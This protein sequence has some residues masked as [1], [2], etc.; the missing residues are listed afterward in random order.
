MNENKDAKIIM[1]TRD[2]NEASVVMN[3]SDDRERC[4]Y[5]QRMCNLYIN[6]LVIQRVLYLTDIEEYVLKEHPWLQIVFEWAKDFTLMDNLVQ[7]VGNDGTTPTEAV[8]KYLD[9]VW[10]IF[11]KLSEITGLPKEILLGERQ[12]NLGIAVEEEARYFIEAPAEELDEYFAKA[13]SEYTGY[14][15]GMIDGANTKVEPEYLL[16]R[17]IFSEL[18]FYKEEDLR[19]AQRLIDRGIG[20]YTI[21]H[22][23]RASDRTGLER[24][25]K[26]NEY[27]HFGNPKRIKQEMELIRKE[28]RDINKNPLGI[29]YVGAYFY[30]SVMGKIP[31]FCLSDEKKNAILNTLHNG[32][33]N[34]KAVHEAYDLKQHEILWHEVFSPVKYK[35]G[36]RCYYTDEDRKLEHLKISYNKIAQNMRL[37]NTIAEK[38]EYYRNLLASAGE[39]DF[40]KKV[41]CEDYQK[42]EKQVKEKEKQ[43]RAVED[44]LR[45]IVILIKKYD[46]DILRYEQKIK[47]M[48]DDTDKTK[49]EQQLA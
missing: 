31:N 44:R 6:Y 46:T 15:N 24:G 26:E 13:Y 36:D 3:I 38:R 32:E 47:E 10:D 48:T 9:D 30:L 4:C 21:P 7:Y 40:V 11:E 17:L 39:P 19:E 8:E 45:E 1:D 23:T 35:L 42:I 49:V 28:M 5:M 41:T 29:N 34:I 43:F 20:F 22:P 25:L 14:V 18:E 37:L 33:E 16:M 27:V 2:K 12:I